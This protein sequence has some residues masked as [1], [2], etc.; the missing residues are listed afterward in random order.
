MTTTEPVD[1][2]DLSLWQN[3]FPDELFTML[4]R[5]RPVF[6]HRLTD[7]VARTVTR[8]FWVTTKHRHALRIHRDT[9][10]FTAVDGPLIQGIGPAGAFPNIINM[11]P[12][13]Q[14]KR[15]RVMSH[16]FTP[17]AIGK[18]ENGIRRRAAA[19]VDRLLE[20]GTGDWIEDVADVLPMA[21]IG[22]IIGIPEKDRP[23]IFATFDRILK[24]GPSQDQ[25][26]A[27]TEVFTYAV[28]LTAEKRR[29]P[30]DDIWSAL[31]T[32]VIT[33]EHGEQLSIPETELES[34]FFVLAFAGSDTTKNAL[35]Y[36]LQAFVADPA[37]IERYRTD[38][39]I[40]SAAVE[41]VLRWSSPVAFWT[42]TTRVDV[43]MDGVAIPAGQRV[44]A[45]LR[46]ANRDEEIFD[47]PF[48]FD[49][50]RVDNPH[51][52]FGGG[53]AHYCLGAMLARAEIRAVLDELL[54]R[55]DHISLGPATVSYPHLA[56]NMTIFD[57]LP[58]TVW[59]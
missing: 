33:D 28:D 51:V 35:A 31:A 18:L 9:D 25:V 38:E 57:A 2:S 8:D 52:T 42:R 43:E 41:E 48:R 32:A 46:S 50:G 16:A 23:Q 34:F 4:R 19:L 44:V 24:A 39:S 26:E 29:H 45:M 1:L 17:R 40:R 14:T 13:E 56:N 3:G 7:G 5:E 36:G 11:D 22:D 30:V 15:R 10:A 55:A 49:I 37:Q 59:A 47:D 53:G 21:V 58:I 54:C 6:H 20:S 12:P 27:F